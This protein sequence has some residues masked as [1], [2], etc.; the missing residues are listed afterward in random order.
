MP[1]SPEEGTLAWLKYR[2]SNI[3]RANDLSVSDSTTH[4]VRKKAQRRISIIAGKRTHAGPRQY[5]SFRNDQ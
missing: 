5:G 4:D 2:A 3:V 1:L